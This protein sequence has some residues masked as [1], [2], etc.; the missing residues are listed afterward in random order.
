MVS[1]GD[2]GIIFKQKK[3]TGSAW[4]SYLCDP[5][6]GSISTATYTLA[7]PDGLGNFNTGNTDSMT[8]V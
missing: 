1:I 8:M 4:T 6:T 7:D 3:N 2:D 5:D